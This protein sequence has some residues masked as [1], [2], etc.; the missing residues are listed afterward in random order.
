MCL[1]TIKEEDESCIRCKECNGWVHKECD[2][3]KKSSRGHREEEVCRSRE[4]SMFEGENEEESVSVVMEKNVDEYM[5]PSCRRN[6][7][8]RWILVVFLSV[9]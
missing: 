1:H 4:G 3:G 9:R 5:C 6:G 2:G 7:W 8:S